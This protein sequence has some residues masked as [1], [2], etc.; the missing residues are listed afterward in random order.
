MIEKELKRLL[1]SD[2]YVLNSLLS[3]V[4]AGV[5]FMI[6]LVQIILPAVAYQRRIRKVAAS[7][8][9]GPPCHWLYGNIHKVC[10]PISYFQNSI[11]ILI[12]SIPCK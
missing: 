10:Y 9:G 2:G 3:E 6:V 7:V 5:L 11:C 4:I 12:G 8:G 1:E